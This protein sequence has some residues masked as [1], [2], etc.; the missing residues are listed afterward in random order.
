MPRRNMAVLLSLGI[1]SSLLHYG[2]AE[3]QFILQ[4][5]RSDVAVW[6]GLIGKATFGGQD[7][8]FK[9]GGRTSP[10][11]PALSPH[12][13]LAGDHADKTSVASRPS[14]CDAPFSRGLSLKLGRTELEPTDGQ[15]SRI[16]SSSTQRG[17]GL[18]KID[19]LAPSSLTLAII[20]CCCCCGLLLARR[21]LWHRPGPGPERNAAITRVTEAG[22]L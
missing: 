15:A 3:A 21:H 5:E 11:L 4:L 17:Q 22:S 14:L 6:S 18:V 2:K 16:P 1:A 20:G 13:L 7:S 12:L 9:A 8:R 19:I 10:D